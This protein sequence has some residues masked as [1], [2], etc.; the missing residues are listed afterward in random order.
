MLYIMTTWVTQW[1]AHRQVRHI[2]RARHFMQLHILQHKSPCHQ[3]SLFCIFCQTTK[4]GRKL[5]NLSYMWCKSA[6]KHK[7]KDQ[8]GYFLEI[9]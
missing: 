1:T 9:L 5:E 3:I 6:V 8:F 7:F 2:D 4:V